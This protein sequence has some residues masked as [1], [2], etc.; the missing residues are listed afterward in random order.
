MLA[1]T[2]APPIPLNLTESIQFWPYVKLHVHEIAEVRF[3]FHD[4]VGGAEPQKYR[5]RATQSFPKV[6]LA[7][8]RIRE[9]LKDASRPSRRPIRT[10]RSERRYDALRRSGARV[11]TPAA[12]QE[13]REA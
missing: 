10:Y 12:H 6:A 5:R 13:A 9:I 4:G 3:H 2:T 8:N 11:L 1:K 7:L